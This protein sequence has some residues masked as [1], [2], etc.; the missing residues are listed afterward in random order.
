M[1]DVGVAAQHYGDVHEDEAV[2]V[3]DSDAE[4]DQARGSWD[5][6]RAADCLIG[7]SHFATCACL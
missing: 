5:T 2:E 6:G 3:D 1:Q 7:P 4:R